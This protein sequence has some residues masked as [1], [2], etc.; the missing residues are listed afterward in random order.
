MFLAQGRYEDAYK[1]Q[2]QLV[3]VFVKEVLQKRK[4]ENWFLPIIFQLCSDLR[5]CARAVGSTL[6]QAMTRN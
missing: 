4:D 3:L 5:L 1:A 6:C 2:E